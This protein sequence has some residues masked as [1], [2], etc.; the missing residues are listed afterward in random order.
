M[1]SIQTGEAMKKVEMSQEAMKKTQDA[2]EKKQDY[3]ACAFS[4]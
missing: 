4:K 3:C 1:E 2:M